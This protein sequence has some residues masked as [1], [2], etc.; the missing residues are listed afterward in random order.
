MN[1]KNGNFFFKKSNI[2]ENNLTFY[3]ELDMKEWLRYKSF[4]IPILRSFELKLIK[5]IT[6]GIET[7]DKYILKKKF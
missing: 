2:Q 4:D 7:Y 5:N 6:Y 1:K 3:I